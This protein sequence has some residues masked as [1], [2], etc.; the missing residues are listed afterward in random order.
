MLYALWR[1]GQPPGPLEF[2]GL[3]QPF[4]VDE[5]CGFTPRTV[6]QTTW[7]PNERLFGS[8]ALCVPRD[9]RLR[10]SVLRMVAPVLRYP[11][12]S[13]MLMITAFSSLEAR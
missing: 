3:E 7:T 4:D 11:G 13:V 9:R 8:G 5:N 12:V 1:E 2:L 10:N 6:S